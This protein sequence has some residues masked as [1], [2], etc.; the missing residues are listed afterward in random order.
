MGLTEGLFST[1]QLWLTFVL[2]CTGLWQ[3]WLYLDKTRLRNDQGVQHTLF[4]AAVIMGFLWQMRAGLLPGLSI[5]LLGIT[6]VTL[7]LGW[8]AAVFAGLSALMISVLTG[9]EP[10]QL[11]AVNGLITVMVPALVTYGVVLWERQRGFRNFFA[12]IFVCG[13]F[14][15]GLATAIAG[16]LTVLLLWTGGA[17]S[18][19]ELVHDYVRYMPLFILPE[20]VVNGM[21]ITGLMVFHPERLQTLDPRRY[22]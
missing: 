3:A 17:Y 12:Y 4:G 8:S 11:F 22:L 13:F 1:W 2:F 14:G 18:W 16:A 21:V 10:W 20:A 19:A 7:M 6:A 15:A 5:H 9:R